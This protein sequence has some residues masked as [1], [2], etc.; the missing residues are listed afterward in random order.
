MV[1][2]KELSEKQF[3]FRGMFMTLFIDIEFL[4][5]DTL[6][7]TLVGDN[8]LKFNLIEFIN[9]KLTLEPKITL[10]NNVLKKKYSSLHTEYKDDLEKLRKYNNLRNSFAHKRIEMDLKNKKLYFVDLVEGID[11][12]SGFTYDELE[13]RIKELVHLLNQ[14]NKLHNKLIAL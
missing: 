10:L 6:A 8:E 7:T 1:P 14:L 3:R 2:N 9:P 4:L 12:K 5:G 13:K 11:N